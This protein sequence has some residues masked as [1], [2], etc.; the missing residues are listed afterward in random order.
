LLFSPSGIQLPECKQKKETGY[1]ITRFLQMAYFTYI[2]NTTLSIYAT[3][4]RKV[5]LKL[6]TVYMYMA[7][8]LLFISKYL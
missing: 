8:Y 3:N 6:L 4:I 1:I 2:K 7:I 5:C